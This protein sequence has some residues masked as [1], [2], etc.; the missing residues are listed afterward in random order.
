MPP[1]P[2]V[3][4]TGDLDSSL[5]HEPVTSAINKGVESNQGKIDACFIGFLKAFDSFWQA[6]LTLNCRV[7]EPGGEIFWQRRRRAPIHQERDKNKQRGE[8]PWGWQGELHP[9][10]NP[11]TP[12]LRPAFAPS[13]QQGSAG[14][15]LGADI[16]PL[17]DFPVETSSAGIPVLRLGLCTAPWD[18]RQIGFPGK[19]LKIDPGLMS[20]SEEGAGISLNGSGMFQSSARAS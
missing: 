10:V 1:S 11:C 7:M 18:S 15:G 9:G 14:G 5:S 6:G 8:G 2:H 16:S 4:A 3:T 19:V 13:V 12:T 20:C 17:Q